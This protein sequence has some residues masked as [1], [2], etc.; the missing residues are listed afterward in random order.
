VIRQLAEHDQDHRWRVTAILR[1]Y[2]GW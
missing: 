2:A 1:G